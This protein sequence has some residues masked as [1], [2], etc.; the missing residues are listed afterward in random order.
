[1][2]TK[3]AFQLMYPLSSAMFEFNP[4]WSVKNPHE[5]AFHGK[6]VAAAKSTTTDQRQTTIAEMYISDP[7]ALLHGARYMFCFRINFQI[8]VGI[9][10]VISLVK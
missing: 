1:M 6:F 2:A 4:V 7:L 3:L 9:C 8:V 10:D 5:Y